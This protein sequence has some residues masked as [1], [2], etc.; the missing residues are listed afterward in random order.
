MEA[1]YFA[2]AK[3]LRRHLG[4]R[5]LGS[6]DPSQPA[7]VNPKLHLRN[8]LGPLPYTSLVAAEI[9]AGLEAT[10]ILEHSPSFGGF[11]AAVKN[12]AGETDAS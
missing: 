2:D 12:G 1:W 5:D 9:A 8:L 6:V 3:G 4:G 10:T 11:I 7:I